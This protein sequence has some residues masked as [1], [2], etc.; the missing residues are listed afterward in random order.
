MSNRDSALSA[1]SAE[2]RGCL[3]GASLLGLESL[4]GLPVTAEA[5]AAL[6]KLPKAE[7]AALLAQWMAELQAPFPTGMERLHPSW[8]AEALAREPEDLWPALLIGIPNSVQ[9][10]ACLPG[11]VIPEAESQAWHLDAVAEMQRHV[12][13]GLAPLCVIPSGRLGAR[14]CRLSCDEL[15]AEIDRQGA[16]KLREELVREGMASLHAVAGRLPAKLG[17]PWLEALGAGEG[18]QA[19]R[20][21]GAAVAG[22]PSGGRPS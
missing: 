19:K 21:R 18:H 11:E 6:R 5:W 10:R 17:R 1:L 3:L 20:P 2:E 8:V 4:A 15:L 14:L 12:F 7:R 22:M 13:A 9:V 16:A